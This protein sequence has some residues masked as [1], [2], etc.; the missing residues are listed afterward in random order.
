MDIINSKFL[1][2]SWAATFGFPLDLSASHLSP[3]KVHNAVKIGN[4]SRENLALS[5]LEGDAANSFVAVK[6]VL[7]RNE[8]LHQ[9][10]PFHFQF[11]RL[12][13]N[14]KGLSSIHDLNTSHQ[15]KKKKKKK[16]QKKKKEERQRKEDV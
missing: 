5:D 1:V 8:L 13:G 7:L 12:E 10:H 11:L 16:G 4:L 9:L 6:E 15:K 14:V 2:P 3:L